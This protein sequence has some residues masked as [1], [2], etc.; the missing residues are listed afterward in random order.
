MH[1]RSQIDT[2]L[3]VPNHWSDTVNVCP[4][5]ETGEAGRN[6]L[7]IQAFRHERL[8]CVLRSVRR[9]EN[10]VL[11]K[12]RK[13]VRRLESFHRRLGLVQLTISNSHTEVC[14]LKRTRGVSGQKLSIRTTCSRFGRHYKYP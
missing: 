7:E 10:D 1:S 11:V 14:V 9:L 13:L 4:Q 8:Y 3:V 6:R 12:R 2:I 5:V